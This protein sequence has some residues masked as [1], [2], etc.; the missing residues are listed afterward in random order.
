MNNSTGEKALS[1]IAYGFVLSTPVVTPSGRE[2]DLPYKRRGNVTVT[3]LTD[4]FVD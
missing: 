3:P 4:A 1:E 2:F